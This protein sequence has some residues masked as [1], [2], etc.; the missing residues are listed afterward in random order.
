[1][2]ISRTCKPPERLGNPLI[3]MNPQEWS[4]Q[5][6]RAAVH[7]KR[8]DRKGRPFPLAC[9]LSREWER[10]LCYT[11]RA[12]AARS[13]SLPSLGPVSPLACSGLA[14]AAV[15]KPPSVHHKHPELPTF[16]RGRDSPPCFFSLCFSLFPPLRSRSSCAQDQG[17]WLRAVC[18]RALTVDEVK[19][20]NQT[21]HRAVER[22]SHVC[23]KERVWIVGAEAPSGPNVVTVS[24]WNVSS[25]A[26]KGECVCRRH[27]CLDCLGP[28]VWGEGS[29]P[30]VAEA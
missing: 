19:Q 8:A 27:V 25:D 10:S 13:G 1:M 29:E 26:Q 4:A 3:T 15:K 17:H 22:H 24:S 12:P 20:P 5:L 28:S 21:T 16:S 23:M 2:Q 7:P 9:C 18:H 6:G 30:K 14:H 11:H